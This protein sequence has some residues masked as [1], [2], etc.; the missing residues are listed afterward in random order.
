[1]QWN[2]APRLG[3][4]AMPQIYIKMSN[5]IIISPVNNDIRIIATAVKL[6]NTLVN[7]GFSR[8]SFL[9]SAVDYFPKYQGHENAGRLVSWWLYRVHDQQINK[10]MEQLI[11][12]L[13]DE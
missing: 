9:S 13:R 7:M 1:M 12:F 8:K 10:D 2:G 6:K 4:R 3:F 5:N 11:Q